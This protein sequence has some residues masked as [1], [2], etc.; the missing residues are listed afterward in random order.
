MTGLTSHHPALHMLFTNTILIIAACQIRS[1]QATA[2]HTLFTNTIL[3]TAACQ[4]RAVQHC[5]TNTNTLNMVTATA[6]GILTLCTLVEA[7]VP[8]VNSMQ[9]IAGVGVVSL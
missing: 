4:I 7:E 8:K 1:V 6:C 9:C 3:I 5:T 2:L